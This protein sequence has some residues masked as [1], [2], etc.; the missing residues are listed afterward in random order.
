MG[1]AARAGKR[2]SMFE[3]TL[4]F[5]MNR[6]S[7]RSYTD[8]PVEEEKIET[9]LKAAMS[10]PSA[11]NAQ[12]WELI[13]TRDKTI[14]DEIRQALSSG[15]YNAP[16]AI[17]VCA[18]KRLCRHT[19]EMWVQD[20]S[21]MMQ[22]ILLCATAL[23]LASVW[24]GVYG[25]PPHEPNVK[26]VSGIMN[27]PEHVLPLGIAYIGYSNEIQEPRTQYDPTRIYKEKYDFT[28]KHRARPK[29][30]KHL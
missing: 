23:G 29:N 24:I 18:N 26:K 19:N 3:D 30:M 1:V 20:C 5:F 8:I 14:L 2:G 28:R 17:T 11:C 6:R 15:R 4:C 12:P 9:I 16:C 25:I 7:I 27:L 10:A 13:I 22:N 21:A